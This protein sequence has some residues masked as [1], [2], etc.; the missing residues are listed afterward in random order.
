M[1]TLVPDCNHSRA[2]SQS[3]AAVLLPSCQHIHIFNESCPR[4]EN[5]G[6]AP[7]PD[8]RQQVYGYELWTYPEQDVSWLQCARQSKRMPAGKPARPPLTARH[9]GSLRPTTIESRMLDV[10]AR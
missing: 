3:L 10:D 7:V 6:V 2:S 5:Y 8:L 1:V 9:A 4:L